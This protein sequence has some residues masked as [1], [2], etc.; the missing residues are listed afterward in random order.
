M[1][2]L[3]T[4][5]SGTGKS[6]VRRAIAPALGPDIICV[7]FGTLPGA[8]APW[9]LADRQRETESLVRFARATEL[10]GR[11]VLFCGDPVAPGEILAAP[12]ADRIAIAICLLD[13]DTSAR[14]HRLAPRGPDPNVVHHLAFDDWMRE[15]A[16]NST[17]RQHVLTCGGWPDMA[18]DRW[19]SLEADDERWAIPVVDTSHL[20]V[21]AV[22][23]RVTEWALAALRREA[24]VFEPGWYDH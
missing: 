9:T 7:E 16:T 19:T 12:S 4:G 10:D 1:L 18:W 21:A 20:P 17:T 14:T 3:V 11:H 13:A 15:H 8:P 2:L 24:P 5:A 22:A 6:T 23:A